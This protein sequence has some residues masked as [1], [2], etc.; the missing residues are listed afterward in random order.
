MPRAMLYFKL[1]Q[2]K[3]DFACATQG[4]SLA[5]ALFDI[6][7]MFRRENKNQEDEKLSEY[8]SKLSDEFYDTLEYY[9]INLDNLLE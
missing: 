1:P 5:L 9:S 4:E 8:V 7:N 6:A 2:E 3:Y